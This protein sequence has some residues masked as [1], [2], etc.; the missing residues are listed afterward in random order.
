MAVPAII[1][2]VKNATDFI[3]ASFEKIADTKSYAEG[4]NEIAVDTACR[5][6]ALRIIENSKQLDDREKLA[7]I[8]DL[9]SHIDEQ[10]TKAASEINEHQLLM[11]KIFLAVLSAGISL[12]VDIISKAIK[13]KDVSIIEEY[14][15]P[16]LEQENAD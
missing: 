15:L 2:L 9:Q 11:A 6:T 13:E 12:P 1:T 14:D 3:K 16:E 8:K 10:K 7:Q 5:D 4:V